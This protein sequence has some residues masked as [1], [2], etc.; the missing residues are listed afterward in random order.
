MILEKFL[1]YFHYITIISPRKRGW[2]FSKTNLNQ[3]PSPKDA[4][5]QVWLKWA[6][7]FLD[8]FPLEK[9]VVLL[10]KKLK[11]PLTNWLR[12]LCVQFDWNWISGLSGSGED[13]NMKSLQTSWQSTETLTLAYS[14]GELKWTISNGRISKPCVD[15]NLGWNRIRSITRAMLVAKQRVGLPFDL[16]SIYSIR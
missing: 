9:G 16:S 11:C 10:L 15:R 12:M 14:S 4:L 5:Y 3:S 6:Q 13:E 7:M 2:L 8:I 1:M